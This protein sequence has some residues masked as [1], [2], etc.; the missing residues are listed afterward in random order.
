VSVG[1][2]PSAAFITGYEISLN[3]GYITEVGADVFTYTYLNLTYGQTYIAGVK[4][5]YPCGVSIPATYTFGSTYLYPPRNLGDAYV[6]NTNEIPLMWNPPMSVAG[7]AR[8]SNVENSPVVSVGVTSKG[9]IP[10]ELQQ[11][12]DSRPSQFLN[13]NDS[14]NA[15]IAG[16]N[17][18]VPSTFYVA[19]MGTYT[20]TVIGNSLVDPSTGDFMNDEDTYMLCA[21]DWGATLYSVDITTGAATLIAPFSG[22]FDDVS[23]MAVDRTTNTMYVSMTNISASQIGTLDVETGAITLI[24]SSTT[25]APGLI[26]IAIDASGQMYGWD[27]VTDASYMID[28]ETGTYTQIGSLGFDANYGQGGN[29]SAED[30][31]IYLTAFNNSTFQG[32]L[33]ALDVA[34]GGT[35]FLGV[36]PQLQCTAF[37]VPAT[38]GSGG[39]GGVPAGL[40]SFN[41]YQDGEFLT[42]VPYADQSPE[43]FVNYVLNPVDPGTYSFDVSAVYDLSVFGLTGT[44]ESAWEGTDVVTVVWGFPLPFTETFDQGSFDFNNWRFNENAANW[45]INS[46]SGNGAPSAEFTWDPLLTDGYS[47]TL[48]S[49]PLLGDLITEGNIWL[50]FDLKLNN[51]NATGDEKMKVE[52]FNGSTWSQVA[53]FDNEESFDYTSNHINITAGAKGRVFQ[54]RFNAIGENSFDVISWFVDNINIYRVCTPPTSLTGEYVYNGGTNYGAEV[55]WNGAAGTNV[56]E[57]LFYDD[58][59]NVDGIGGPASF[60]WAV[61]FDPS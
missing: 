49:N 14:Y 39:G 19:D 5:K 53:I 7:P 11:H 52:V 51:R 32:E 56:S 47:A 10:A 61:K 28:K 44:A 27:I 57:W 29:F 17:G 26:Q 16:P 59:V 4:A 25:D 8:L 13:P 1:S 37:G 6:Y 40:V 12:A 42:N 41:L 21:G 50:D 55:C 54:V 24:G 3:N 18:G 58:G 20:Y 38:G 60:S 30:G 33:R 34:T 48:T 43:E 35:T 31:I 36:L 22:G 46:Q 23:G 2:G 9:A 15:W 45:T